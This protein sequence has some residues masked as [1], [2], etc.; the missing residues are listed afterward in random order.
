MT[1]ARFTGTTKTDNTERMVK[2]DYQT[3][4]YAATIALTIKPTA[5]YTLA[6]CAQLTGAASITANVGSSTAPPYVGDELVMMFETDGTQRVVT[7]STGFVSSGTLT[8]PANKKATVIA[9]FD[10]AAWR[11]TA[12]EIT[13]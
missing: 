4:A 2:R 10:G 11:V 12:R 8:I 5:A 9:F 6:K 1:V 7:F 13:A 3:P